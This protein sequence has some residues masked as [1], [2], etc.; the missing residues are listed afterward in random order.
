M[1]PPINPDKQR[2]V[3]CHY[4]QGSRRIKTLNSREKAVEALSFTGEC[5]MFQ[6]PRNMN[7]NQSPLNCGG[8]CYK[9][10]LEL[11]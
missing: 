4:W 7:Y 6:Y 5:N 3:T 11:P 10:W 9:R 8:C 2:C 1:Y